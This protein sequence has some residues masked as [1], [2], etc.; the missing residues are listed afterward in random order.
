MVKDIK[1]GASDGYPFLLTNV[2][3]L[4]YFVANDGTGGYELWKSDGTSTGTIMV[5]D[6]N[7]GIGNSYPSHLAV[8]NAS[9]ISARKW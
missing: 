5:K 6:I 7:S 3:G 9:S 2:N 8:L 1:S 4:V